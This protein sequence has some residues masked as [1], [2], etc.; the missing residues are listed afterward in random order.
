MATSRQIEFGPPRA[1]A[2]LK[3]LG[4]YAT[5]ARFRL[6]WLRAFVSTDAR[7]ALHRD[8]LL[9]LAQAGRPRI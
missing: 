3:T 5:L 7:V 6:G 8:S 1:T 2:G 9:G 4:D